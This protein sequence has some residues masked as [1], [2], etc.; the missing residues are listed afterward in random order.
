V[1][2][3]TGLGL[4]G[5]RPAVYGPGGDP[6]GYTALDLRV[7]QVADELGPVRRLV[8]IEAG[9]D[10]DSLVAYLAALRGGHPVLLAPP[11]AEGPGAGPVDVLVETYR[12][13]VICS[14]AGGS[15]RIR[16]Q[17]AGTAHRLHPDLALLLS[18]SGTTG[19]AKL[20]RLSAANL[21]ANAAA[22]AG[23]LDI[24]AEDRA[25]VSLPMHYCYGLSVINSN[26]S[27]GAALWLPDRP[28]TDPRFWAGFRE[29]RCTSLHGVPHTFELLDRVGFP[30]LTLPDLRYVTQAGGRLS[31]SAVRRYAE[32]G[33]RDGW[34]L[35]VM[36]GQTEATAR[37]AYLPPE[38]A[39][40]APEA[41]GVPIAGGS[42]SI[43]APPGQVG[44]LVYSGPNVMLGYAR[45][46]EELALGRTVDE[47][48]TGDLGR[49]RADG[50]YEVVGRSNRVIKPFGLR[51]DLEHVEHLLH[52][53][54]FGGVC[55]GTDDE[56]VVVV[57]GR[58]DPGAV[59]RL[60][61]GRID[62]PPEAVR[63]LV[64]RE[65]PRLA[66]GKVDH[67]A[68]A[69][70]ARPGGGI[71]AR[72]AALGGPARPGRARAPVGRRPRTVREAFRAVFPARDLPD[73][74]TF[75]GLG[76]DS[77]SY[78]R[79]TVELQRVLGHLP[80]DW[81]STPINR[82]EE[83]R[84]PVNRAPVWL[85]T[86]TMETAVV[87]RAVAIV[88]VVGSHI[89][90]FRLLGGAH[91][92]L[93][94]SGWAFAR[95]ALAPGADLTPSRAVLRS[96]VRT[97]VP[98]VLWIS[99]R[100]SV[101]DDMDFTNA[102]LLNQWLDP[103]AWGYWYVETLC[104]A[105]LLLAV[106]FSVPAVRRLERAHPYRF[107]AVALLVTSAGRLFPDRGNDFSDR[108]M[109][110]H[111]VLWLF[112][113]G[114]LIHRA[115]TPGQRAFT[116]LLVGLLVPDF[117]VGEP[118]RGGLVA[119]GLALLLLAPRTRLPGWAVRPV[120]AV[121]SAS[122]A[123]YLTHYAIYPALLPHLP[124]SVVLVLTVAAG[125][126]VWWGLG[127]LPRPPVIARV[128]RPAVQAETAAAVQARS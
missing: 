113:L 12:P 127:R 124:G 49:R 16:E 122:L 35:F 115:R 29:R 71:G 121:A 37:M 110:V 84:G 56:L 73:D 60:V 109:S 80:P 38:L 58:P 48:R 7:R 51:V 116:L 78:V 36:Y 6:I 75:V 55:T 39:R 40:T 77:L 3:A 28:V 126:L 69:R 76:G 87:L 94:I 17:R 53:E 64:T 117:F 114:W 120:G 125:V 72:W 83:L 95:F 1:S 5:D 50:L 105:L 93:G 119:I 4:H 23:Y 24:R 46:P 13:D 20:V 42:F 107:A 88:L 101:Q 108:L 33:E 41:V 106:L 111:L 90:S 9:R 100:A 8:L 103:H 31:P 30:E 102:L 43:D 27:V 112:V 14:A 57:P 62:L 128:P 52:D 54:G 104:Q 32:L 45:T 22:I 26:L 81:D 99:W 68:V 10:L 63:V 67:G 86:S 19:S 118:A 15:W 70:L 97:A 74:A 44:E 91:L 11:A 61:A 96:V 21:E 92:L 85:R 18:T 2:F 89:G 65:I 59:R 47:L 25:A 82:L 123:V 79:M 66:N 98:S 34:R